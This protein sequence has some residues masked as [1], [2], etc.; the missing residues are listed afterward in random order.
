M[1]QKDVLSKTF[2]APAVVSSS[3][4]SCIYMFKN[5][6]DS[7]ETSEEE[8]NIELRPRGK[9]QQRSKLQR[10]KVGDVILLERE[11][12]EDDNLNKLALQYGCKVADIKKV[13]NFIREQD[14]YALKSIKIPVKN[15][16]VLTETSKELK[17]PQSTSFRSPLALVEVPEP[18]DTTASLS[19]AGSNQLTDF[20]KEI[21]QDIESAVQS[22]IYFNEDHPIDTPGHPL[23]PLS[24]ETVA[25]GADWG[26]Q[27]WNAVF[28]MLLIGIILPVFYVVYFKIQRTG[29]PAS[30]LNLT[31]VPEVS[32]PTSASPGKTSTLKKLLHAISL[33]DS[34]ANNQFPQ[35]QAG[36]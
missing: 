11:I 2:Q 27:W 18:E 4:N 6:S 8:L 26:I 19:C 31:T 23:L 20:F 10:E 36:S 3:P 34:D 17:P 5:N 13:N 28:I 25:N 14:L 15:Y 24:Q 16:G 33:L 35:M 1:R 32:L 12:T 9:E 30:S 29:G 7:D 22:E 21:D